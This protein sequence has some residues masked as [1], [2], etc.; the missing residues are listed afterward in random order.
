VVFQQKG[1][2]VTPEI[3]INEVSAI[4]KRSEEKEI[5]EAHRVLDAHIDHIQR[6]PVT[7]ALYLKR[8]KLAR[9]A[10]KRW[11]TEAEQTSQAVLNAVY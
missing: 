6:N 9:R 1:K 7:D 2:K 3:L 5:K 4:V 11:L 8:V 10:L